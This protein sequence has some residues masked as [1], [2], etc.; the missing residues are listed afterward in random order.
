MYCLPKP[1]TPFDITSKGK[2]G[3]LHNEQMSVSLHSALINL[4]E[5]DSLI[6]TRF[7]PTQETL[8]ALNLLQQTQWSINLDF[9]DFIAYFTLEGKVILPYP[10]DI[11]QIVWQDSDNMMLKEIFI[12]K[13]GL[14][15]R[16]PAMEV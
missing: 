14:R 11:R 5:E 9:L 2:G 8:V 12:E 15:S 13:M 7:E 1:H 6:Y 4:I 10:E 16:D 3:F